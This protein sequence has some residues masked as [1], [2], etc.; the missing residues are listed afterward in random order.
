MLKKRFLRTLAAVCSAA[1]LTQMVPLGSLAEAEPQE[2]PQLH[3]AITDS[4]DQE[5]SPYIPVLVG[6]DEA[7]REENVKYFR[8]SDGAYV[9]AVYQEPVHYRDKDTWKEIDN[10][11][12]ASDGRAGGYL[13]NKDNDFHVALPQTME[14]GQPV[15]VEFQGHSL[16]FSML[17]TAP[18]A[19]VELRQP[20]ESRLAVL[21]DQPR[22][23]V[24]Q[25]GGDVWKKA[26]LS[27][28]SA[29]KALAVAPEF[30]VDETV[31]ESAKV[32]AEK[33]N[34]EMQQ[35]RK[36][37]SGIIYEALQ[38]DVDVIYDLRSRALKESLVLN[39]LPEQTGF[40]FQIDSGTLTARLQEDGSVQFLDGE[41]P[42]YHIAIPYMW[43]AAGAFTEDIAV[44]LEETE[45]GYL[46]TIT[47]SREWLEDEERVYPVTVDPTIKAECNWNTIKDTTAVYADSVPAGFSQKK[48]SYVGKKQGI[49]AVALLYI[50]LPEEIKDTSRLVDARMT[51]QYRQEHHNPNSVDLQINAYQILD[52]WNT[53]DIPENH[54]ITKKRMPDYNSV[55]LDYVISHD[56]ENFWYGSSV[57]LQPYTFNITKAVQSWMNGEPN[58]GIMLKGVDIPANNRW[59]Q[60]INSDF[61]D[62]TDLTNIEYQT[63][64]TFVYTFRDTKGMEDYW[65]RHDQSVGIAGAGAVNDFSGRLVFTHQDAA[66]AGGFMPASVSHV[67]N[68]LQAGRN[69]WSEN[70]GV[71]G[72]PRTGLG[73]K[74]NIQ[75]SLLAISSSGSMKKFYDMGYRYIYTDA[76]GTEHYFYEKDGG[77]VDEDGLN[78]TIR[79]GMGYGGGPRIELQDDSYMNFSTEGVLVEVFNPSGDYVK[80]WHGVTDSGRWYVGSI[81][82]GAGKGIWLTIDGGGYLTK[83]TDSAGRETTYTYT[84]VSNGRLL[85]AIHYPDGSSSSYT[86][87]G[88]NRLTAAYSTDG[89]RVEYSYDSRG[90]VTSITEYGQSAQGQKMGISYPDYNTT[91]FR[92]SGE[93]DVYGNGDD[94]ETTYIFN[95]FGQTVSTTTGTADG[96]RNFGGSRYAYTAGSD[97]EASDIPNRLKEEVTAKKTVVNLIKNPG[98]ERDG[99]WDGYSWGPEGSFTH[100]RRG[101]G[102]YESPG[103]LE[104]S[105]TRADGEATAYY[106]QDINAMEPGKTYTLSAYVKTENLYVDKSQTSEAIGIELSYYVGSTH[107]I[108]P[109]TWISDQRDGWQRLSVTVTIP[110][111]AV[112]A[113]HIWW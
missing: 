63:N 49:E 84:S 29:L 32:L 60:L 37:S 33:I 88:S 50:A 109:S 27:G 30:T 20:E 59:A 57:E 82:D 97:K 39:R 102:G 74:L 108:V 77:L 111:T 12:V 105:K 90:R 14:E 110:E 78:M 75:Q 25:S 10:T 7:K 5:A 6:E 98:A 91:V 16:S 51:V 31:T 62:E 101:S 18:T 36:L 54:I 73:W 48:Y 15:R 17:Q 11:L 112:R 83:I 70:Q 2:N 71:G 38:P 81:E 99:A 66:T 96:S 89:H 85:T 24:R 8:R 4:F 35:V 34:T 94:L 92:T 22:E 13:E 56:R 64:P 47:P 52:D 19:R 86:Y 45:D 3:Q 65:S 43:D 40:S 21:Q 44:E 87:D 61:R 68:A 100:T 72:Y 42:V 113:M 69:Y 9:A 103:C 1:L 67:Y 107:Y 41:T 106:R 104:I 58:F 28:V 46:Y 79:E 55:A 93:D 76:D 23:L 80:Y 26:E 95:H 53:S